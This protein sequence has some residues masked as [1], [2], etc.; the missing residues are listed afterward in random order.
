MTRRRWIADEVSGDRAFLFGRNAEHLVRVLRA[1]TGQRFEIATPEG[2]R[3]GEIVEI[4]PERVVFATSPLA[5]E[6]PRQSSA[7][8]HL[9]LSIFK[10]DR[11][12]WALEKVTELG[13]SRIIPVIAGRTDAHLAS[14]AAKRVERWR[15]I[16]HEAS[17]QSRRDAAPEICHPARLATATET[18]LGR[19]IVLAE[20][21]RDLRLAA[22]I[23]DA[24]DLSMAVGP[25]GGWTDSELGVFMNN[26]WTAV[27]LGTNILRA[28]TAAIAAVS[29]ARFLSG[30]ESPTHATRR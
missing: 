23:R 19:R 24:A 28:E 6:E 18:A 3:I 8:I 29:V 7:I 12:E 10:F 21:E 17:Q 14:A 20:S 2:V 13:V 15:R 27:S 16:V 26:Q 11:F 1:R 22:L 9:Y 4:A 5:H 30:K 25:E